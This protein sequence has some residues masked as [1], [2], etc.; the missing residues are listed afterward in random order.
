MYKTDFW[1]IKGVLINQKIITSCAVTEVRNI[2][3]KY[4]VNYSLFLT[5][6]IT[7]TVLTTRNRD[8]MM[9]MFLA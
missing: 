2:L 3:I 1:C 5:T 6:L 8:M 7:N 9:I 4:N